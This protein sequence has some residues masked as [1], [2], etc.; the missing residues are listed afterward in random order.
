MSPSNLRSQERFLGRS[1]PSSADSR[2]PMK[3]GGDLPCCEGLLRSPSK[4]GR[5]ARSPLSPAGRVFLWAG[6]NC[7]GSPAGLWLLHDVWRRI[8]TAPGRDSTKEPDTPLAISSS[9]IASTRR[10]LPI[11]IFRTRRF[12]QLRVLRC[13]PHAHT[14]R[15]SAFNPTLNRLVPTFLVSLRTL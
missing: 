3:L 7:G 1:R 14:R 6:V 4:A 13:R 2:R 10:P 5:V 9:G 15:A 11:G 12:S 8:P